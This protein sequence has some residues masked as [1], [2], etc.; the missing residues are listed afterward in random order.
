[1]DGWEMKKNKN[2]NKN[3]KKLDEFMI[4]PFRVDE[5]KKEIDQEMQTLIPIL[6]LWKE[7]S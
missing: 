6:P 7:P 1:M 3:K 2:K 4:R 5:V